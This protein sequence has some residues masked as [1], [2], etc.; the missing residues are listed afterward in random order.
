[1]DIAYLKK[2]DLGL[3]E[4]LYKQPGEITI[5][6]SGSYKGTYL[7]RLDNPGANKK[8]NIIALW[9]MFDLTPFGLNFYPK[10]G[11]WYFFHP[12]FA[13]G[14]FTPTIGPSR[15]REAETIRLNY[16]VS[17]LP[18]PIRSILYDEIKPLEENL[19]LGIG[20]FNAEKDT[21]DQFF[22]A[23]EKVS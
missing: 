15:W 13:M 14:K 20:G 2:C 8:I 11:D 3:L 17:G 4:A 12:S 9:A 23:I 1:M 18:K 16:Q 19:L 6:K 22:F 7:K 10:Y 21:G 5:P